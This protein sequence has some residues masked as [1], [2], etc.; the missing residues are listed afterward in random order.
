M[1]VLYSITNVF[2]ISLKLAK[3]RSVFVQYLGF[4]SFLVLKDFKSRS[5]FSAKLYKYHNIS[6]EE[7]Q[8]VSSTKKLLSVKMR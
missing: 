7:Q 1:V 3:V 6:L 2:S 4:E 5:K 8:F